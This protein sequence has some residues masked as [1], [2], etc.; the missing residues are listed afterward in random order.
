M[1][2]AFKQSIQLSP[3]AAVAQNLLQ[4]QCA[5]GLFDIDPKTLA[6]R[7][8]ALTFGEKPEL[9]NGNKGPKPHKISMAAVAL[10]QGMREFDRHSDEYMACFLS[11]GAILLEM[12]A[13]GGNYPLT[14]KDAQ[15]LELARREYHSHEHGDHYAEQVDRVTASDPE[16]RD[17]KAEIS[18]RLRKFEK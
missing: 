7:L 18:E 1:F 13:N 5:T 17:R 11:I 16:L 2:R 9:V 3:A 8:V 14:G 12:E 10:A 4:R 15:F 6:N